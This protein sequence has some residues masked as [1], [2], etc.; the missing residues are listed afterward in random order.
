MP[1][2]RRQKIALV[3]LMGGMG[4]LAMAGAIGAVFDD[5][6]VKRATTTTTT[7]PPVTIPKAAAFGPAGQELDALTDAG[8]RVDYAAT[9]SVED[10]SLPEAVIEQTV[11]VWRKGPLFRS[12][13]V[14]RRGRGTTRL[15]YI[16]GGPVLRKCTTGVD[17]VQTCETVSAVPGDLPAVFVRSLQEAADKGKDVELEARDDDVA[18]YVARC[19]EAKG[20]GELCVAGDGV[21]LRLKLKG[22]T[23]ELT[24]IED[25]VPA[26]AFDTAG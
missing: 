20:V 14:E 19:Y 13:I 3:V 9:Y 6:P 21:M 15:T 22:A 18:G 25:V 26:T 10:P 12:D 24:S 5:P 4:A 11:E 8:R 23:I 2:A 17:A 7:A 1:P 16:S